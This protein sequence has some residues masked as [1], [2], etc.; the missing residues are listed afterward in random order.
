[1][2]PEFGST[3][4]IRVNGAW[5]TRLHYE[6]EVRDGQPA[7]VHVR[8][9]QGTAE[10][11]R[12][13]LD[14]D[15]AL[16]LLGERN[17]AVIDQQVAQRKPEEN[18]VQGELDGPRL[19]YRDVVLPNSS[20]AIEE[21][22]AVMPNE[23][24][25]PIEGRRLPAERDAHSM[26]TQVAARFL[27]DG[28]K[29]YF[30]DRTL[31]FVDGGNQLRA[32]TENR[33]VIKDLV[34]IAKARDWST[35]EVRGSEI[36]RRE[37]WKEAHAQGL[38]VK[39][40]TPTASEL[41]LA[42]RV[43]ERRHNKAEAATGPL[44]VPGPADEMGERS[45]PSRRP[46][47][48]PATGV[49]Y[50][51]LVEYGAAPYQ[52]DPQN[53]PSYYVKLDHGGGQLR[54]YW[55]VGLAEALARSW[56]AVALGDAVGI[57]QV[58][59]KPVVVTV[60][61]FDE[62]GQAVVKEV[63]RQRHDWEVEKASYLLEP[64][65][66]ARDPLARAD[67]QGASTGN[68]GSGLAASV[69]AMVDE[70]RQ[71]DQE[72]VA[73]VRSAARTWEETQRSYPELGAAVFSQLAAQQQFADEFVKAGLIREEDRQQVIQAMRERLADQ[74]KRR[75]KI[76]LAEQKKVMALIRQSVLRAANEVGRTPVAGSPDRVADQV[77]RP[78]TLV[79]EDVH[80]RA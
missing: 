19:A 61:V 56:S 28:N 34:A 17:M 67:G 31:A 45:T 64:K 14:R 37:V 42:H 66:R 63:A 46:W 50:G 39:G 18:R 57:R 21:P 73:A 1:M 32:A 69:N 36:F 3:G 51:R 52:F 23:I 44:S 20:L 71:R 9:M 30:D 58:G 15:Q 29:Y 65:G 60:H 70:Q 26:P 5:A 77:Q 55:G 48:N 53:T 74:L 27:R 8:F 16:V 62:Q 35:I 10:V 24:A 40:F 38:A 47:T 79:R 33:A 54:T 7:D 43:H 2:E 49:V 6:V 72:R 41:Q 78:K 22:L 25:Q 11:E 75:D 4:V 76:P 12:A 80:A 68:A 13:V 59:S